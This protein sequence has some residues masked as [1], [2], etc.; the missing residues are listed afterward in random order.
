MSQCG[1]PRVYSEERVQAFPSCLFTASCPPLGW[2]DAVKPPS[3]YW[4]RPFGTLSRCSSFKQP[5][6]VHVEGLRQFLQGRK[7]GD[8][9]LPF[10]LRDVD[11]VYPGPFGELRLSHLPASEFVQ[12]SV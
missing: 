11:T 9:R 12:S 6:H 1:R 10:D 8:L 3:T 7:R 4:P 2:C 5:S